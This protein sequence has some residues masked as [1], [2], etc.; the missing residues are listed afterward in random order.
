[1]LSGCMR[2]S[3]SRR[4]LLRIAEIFD[5]E[6]RRTIERLMTLLIPALTIVLGAL[7]AAIIGAVLAA[8]SS[9]YQAAAVRLSCVN[10]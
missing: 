3:G 5:R 9:A 8:I 10:H 1:M 7:I 4:T 6:T 2:W